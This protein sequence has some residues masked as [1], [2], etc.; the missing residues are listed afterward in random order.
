MT[1]I[2]DA[3]VDEIVDEDDVILADDGRL[4]CPSNTAM[5]YDSAIHSFSLSLPKTKL[6]FFPVFG[7]LLQ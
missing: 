3:D 6:V 7:R 5:T 2:T 4:D 1:N